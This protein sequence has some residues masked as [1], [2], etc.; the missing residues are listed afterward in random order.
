[1]V[2]NTIE[3][4]KRDGSMKVGLNVIASKKQSTGNIEGGGLKCNQC[5]LSKDQPT[6]ADPTNRSGLI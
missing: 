4:R 2:E 6:V 1:M 3:T 5:F